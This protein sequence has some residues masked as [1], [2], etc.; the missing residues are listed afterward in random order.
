MIVQ[1]VQLSDI[2]LLKISSNNFTPVKIGNSDE[3]EQGDGVIAIGSPYNFDFSV[4]FGRV[5]VIY[6]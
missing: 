3:M 6:G 4:T 5:E 2:A 1:Q